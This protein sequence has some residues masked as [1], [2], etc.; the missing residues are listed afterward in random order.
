VINPGKTP[1][2]R[3]PKGSEEDKITTPET[4]PPD[5]VSILVHMIPGADRSPMQGFIKSQGA[6]VKYRYNVVLPNVI[7]V[8]NFPTSALNGLLS[9]PG[10]VRWEEDR[11]VLTHLNDSTRLIRVPPEQI[12]ESG[13]SADGSGVRVCVLDTGIDSDSEMYMTRIDTEAGR[14]FVNNDNNPEDDNGH[15]SHVSGIA[16]G[17]TGL[18]VDFGCEGSEPFRGVAPE[19]TLIG[20]KVLDASGIGQESDILAGINYGAGP[21]IPNGPCDVM[22]MSLGRSYFTSACDSDPIA[23]AANN[24]V[25]LGVVVVA[26]SGNNGISDAIAAPACG[27]KVISVGA[28]Y[29]DTYPNCE[30]P[31][32]DSFEFC[33]L[34]LGSMCWLSCTDSAPSVDQIGCYSNGSAQLDVTAPGCITFSADFGNSPLGIVG[35]CGTSMAAPH[36]AGLAALLLSADPSLTPVEVRQHIRDGAID[37]GA[38]GFDW[39][40][41]YGRIDVTNSLSLVG[42]QC[43][44]NADCDDSNDCTTDT[45]VSG[46]CSNTPIV[47][48]DNDACTTDSCDPALGC[49]YEPI[50]C[51]DGDLCTTDSCNPVSGCVYDPI[52]CSDGELCIDG[53]CVVPAGCGNGVCELGEDCYSCPDD[54]ISGQGEGTCDTCFKGVC[55]GKCNPSKDGPGCADCASSFCCGDGI[56]E[57]GEYDGNCGIDCTAAIPPPSSCGAW[58]A[59]CST[60]ADCCSGL[61]CTKNGRCR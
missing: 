18:S 28:T 47:C 13:L 15:G 41:G 58:N 21:S 9:I 39:T 11:T 30:F 55:D 5:R 17:R 2:I 26:S 20:I 29:D 46:T 12:T 60:D 38:E 51:D 1:I 59:K 19:A 45:C 44:T 24:A 42:P 35:F 7:N 48:N 10:V 32:Q 53:V 37:L 34:W 40:Y 4:G 6:F 56:C 8:R 27:S 61:A 23:Q 54:C 36:V 22:N 25:D 16:V 50:S 52:T 49:Y 31:D 57:G 43:T 14:D 3:G 33:T